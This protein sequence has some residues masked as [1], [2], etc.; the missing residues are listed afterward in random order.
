MS[1]TLR[2]K[3]MVNKNKNKAKTSSRDMKTGFLWILCSNF[4]RNNIK[5]AISPKHNK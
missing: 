5:K 4:D 1:K 3:G 2:I